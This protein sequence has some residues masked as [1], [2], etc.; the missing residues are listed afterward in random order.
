VS[1]AVTVFA[2]VVPLIHLLAELAAFAGVQLGP[3]DNPVEVF[4]FLMTAAMVGAFPWGLWIILTDA[5]QV[6]M[7]DEG[8][9]VAEYVLAA[10]GGYL[11][12]TL[13]V[14]TRLQPFY[15]QFRWF[16]TPALFVCAAALIYWR[17]SR[18]WGLPTRNGVRAVLD[19]A[20][21]LQRGS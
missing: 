3:W 10:I 7:F 12:L 20:L 5:R 8:R 1:A 15:A 21:A 9:E 16:L 11:T 6:D 17:W 18:V 14:C 13:L 2:T 4:I 19:H